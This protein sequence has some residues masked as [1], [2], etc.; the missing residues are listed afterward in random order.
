M[1]HKL[2]TLRL[3]LAR[4]WPRRLG[5]RLVPGFGSLVVL[6]VLMLL[7]LTLASLQIRAMTELTQRFATQDVQRLLRVQALSM[8]IEGAGNALLR[9]MNAPREHRVA[10]YT[11]VDE[12]NR[13]IDGFIAAMADQLD[14]PVQKRTLQHLV[15]ARTVYSQA[16][17]DMADEIE[18]DDLV[19]ARG[20]YTSQVQPALKKMLTDSNKLI[21]HERYR[22]EHQ[23]TEAQKR[24]EQLTL[25]VTGL[26][27]IAFVL[28]LWMALRTT[29]SVVVPLA[30]LEATA[31]RTLKQWA[32]TH[33][34]LSIAVN[35]N[36]RD[37]QDPLFCSRVKQLLEHHGTDPQRLVKSMIE[38]GALKKAPL[39][40]G[41]I[42]G[43]GTRRAYQ[44]A[45]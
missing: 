19:A 15:A 22:I 34:E 33:P 13:R 20:V 16:F 11:D 38:S 8:S 10:E 31:R 27:L 32:I 25:W 4:L 9:L 1:K 45:S 37:L 2:T 6:V 44:F 12:R 28:A 23:A 30:Q 24:F 42:E 5:W 35:M 40:Q 29:R 7:A 36:T 14:D 26:S 43:L 39:M 17:I 18:G 41:L 21:G 3:R